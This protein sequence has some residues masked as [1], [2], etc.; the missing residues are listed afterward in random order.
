MRDPGMRRL[1]ILAVIMIFPF[2]LLADH[3][4][5]RDGTTYYGKFVSG[6]YQNIVFQDDSG[7]QHT[8]DTHQ[9]Q[10]L[11]FGR[12]QDEASA[13]RYRNENYPQPVNNGYAQANHGGYQP[14]VLPAGAQIA[15]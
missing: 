8:F 10:T 9:V 15:V 6:D 3:L 13:N 7:E 4:T 2:T 5:L 14:L 11:E 1:A 12:G